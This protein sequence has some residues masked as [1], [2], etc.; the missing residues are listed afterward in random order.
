[1]FHGSVNQ[2]SHRDWRMVM[3]M[4]KSWIM[5]NWQKVVEFCDQSWNF[6]SFA[7]EF[8]QICALSADIKK[9]S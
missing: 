8:Y 6:T 7:P 5:K 1:M 2:G 9:L 4:E 3:V